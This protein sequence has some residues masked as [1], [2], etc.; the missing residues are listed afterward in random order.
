L[1]A[2]AERI[3]PQSR[4][5]LIPFFALGVTAGVCEEFLYRG[6]AMTAFLRWGLPLWIAVVA[7]S[8][9]FGLAHLYQGRGGFVST[10]ILG[11]LFGA[12]RAAVVSLVPVM[13]WHIGVDLAAGIAGPKYLIKKEDTVEAPA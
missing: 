1:Q 2:L 5:E 6:F 10:T 13:L 7:S 3:L 11:L 4:A 8:L 12:T 9:L